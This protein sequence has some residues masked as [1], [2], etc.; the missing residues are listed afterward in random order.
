MA[1]IFM[2]KTPECLFSWY[3]PEEDDWLEFRPADQSGVYGVGWRKKS[4]VENAGTLA[5]MLE[6]FF[7]CTDLTEV[8]N[9]A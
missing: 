6:Y 5:E 7:W 8:N 2:D 9:H 3:D 4:I 1:T